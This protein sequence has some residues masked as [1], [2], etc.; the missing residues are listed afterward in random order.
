MQ[1]IDAR[2]TLFVDIFARRRVYGVHVRQDYQDVVAK[3]RGRG[4]LRVSVRSAREL[5]LPRGQAT[6]C[7]SRVHVL[8]Y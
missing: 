2:Y 5:D 4:I 7:P 6:L 8:E 1:T 3:D